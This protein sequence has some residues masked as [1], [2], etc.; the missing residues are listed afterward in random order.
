[1]PGELSAWLRGLGP[2]GLAA[3]LRSR[4]DACAAP[5]PASLTEL[6]GRL[7]SRPSVEMALRSLDSGTLRLTE[8]L[9]GLGRPTRAELGRVVGEGETVTTEQLDAALARLQASA[10]A[11]DEDADG[12]AIES[13]AT[14]V[15]RIRSAGAL[16]G[17]WGHPLGLGEPL[18]P[19]LGRLQPDVLQAIITT[20]GL[21]AGSSRSATHGK[22]VAHLTADRIRRL[23][24]D[25]PKDVAALLALLVEDG[26]QTGLPALQVMGLYGLG[27]Q[28]DR[29]VV[30]AVRRALLLPAAWDVVEMPREVGLAL[31]GDGWRAP[32]DLAPPP[33]RTTPN[34]RAAAAEGAARAATFVDLV[35]AVVESVAT[36][37]LA[38]LKF[39]GVGVRELRRL[40]KSTRHGD[41]D[42][43]LALELAAHAG[44]LRVDPDNVLATDTYDTWRLAAPADR[45]TPVA[46]AWWSHEA[47]LTERTDP[48]TGKPRPPLARVQ[49]RDD[50][51]RL[52]QAVV[53]FL[54]GLP[55]G[56]AM[57]DLHDVVEQVGWSAPIRYPKPT[58]DLAEQAAAVWHEAQL[59][60]AVVDGAATSLGAALASGDADDLRSAAETAMPAV[61]ETAVFQ[62]DLTAVV[63]GTP[64]AGLAELLDSVAD[65]E[66]RGNASTWRFSPE[67]VRRFLDRGGSADHVVKELEAVATKSVPQPLT[68]LIGD[69]ARRH[70]HV[71]VRPV[72]C[73][74]VSPDET[75]LAEIAGTRSL[76]SLKPVSLAPTV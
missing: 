49:P 33:L 60:G 19:L 6:A 30:W 40:A 9:A 65:R 37:P 76:S 43:V 34:R 18:R 3:V 61:T 62:A 59:L 64:A 23:A 51:R 14:A 24:A 7:A 16:A 67:S 20:L 53:T 22:V 50:V 26:P 72:K 68:Y 38:L 48:A 29:G 21:S 25:A 45:L 13:G 54:A 73:V 42:V 46:Q 4:P 52:R 15:P 31:R 28:P 8:M 27:R 74:I 12:G 55:D 70:G 2:E 75:L 69:V 63:A 5:A 44:L 35:A 41:T 10:L 36:Q 47:G 1:M 56:E 58:V 57:P 71:S 39:G 66:A 32:L 11:W 17:L